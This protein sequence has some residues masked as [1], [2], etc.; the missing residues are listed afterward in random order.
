MGRTSPPS[1]HSSW[2]Q[3]GTLSNPQPERVAEVA[4]GAE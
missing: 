3:W 4:D 1:C 2:R